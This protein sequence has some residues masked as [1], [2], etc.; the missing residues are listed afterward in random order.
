MIPRRHVEIMEFSGREDLKDLYVTVIS[1][2]AKYFD[3]AIK[4]RNLYEMLDLIN[5]A[6]ENHALY[7]AVYYYN[8]NGSGYDVFIEFLLQVKSFKDYTPY[9]GLKF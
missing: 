1:A 5:K 4:H 8:P 7:D 3:L 6:Q 9:N 2:Y